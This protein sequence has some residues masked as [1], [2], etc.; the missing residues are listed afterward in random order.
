M[1]FYIVNVRSCHLTF[2]LIFNL[3]YNFRYNGLF[4]CFL[5][6]SYHV[7]LVYHNIFLMIYYRN[8]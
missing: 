1:L 2:H 7:M 8:D 6:S 3:Y 4:I 5:L